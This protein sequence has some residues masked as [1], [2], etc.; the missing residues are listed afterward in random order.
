[1]PP[2]RRR[3]E[4]PLQRRLMRFWWR[5]LLVALVLYIGYTI[6]L[7][8]AYR[9][10]EAF[11]AGQ[12]E[13]VAAPPGPEDMALLP[14]GT[15]LL[16]GAIVSSQDRRDRAAPGALYFYDMSSRP[17]RFTRLELPASLVLHPHGL[18]L[19]TATDGQV[20]LHVINH[21]SS[22]RHTVEI[23]AVQLT[24]GAV[25]ALRHRGSV[26]SDLFIHPNG[27]AAAGP[28]SF[29]LTNDRGGG[30]GFIGPRWMHMMENLLQLS[31]STVVYHDG[32]GARVV[33]DNIA[34][35][36]GIEIT[37]DGSTVLVGSTQWRMLLAYTR[38]P[39]SGMLL[40]SGSLP[41]PGGADNVR[42]D[43]NGDLWVAAHPNAF[44]FIGHAMNAEKESPSIILR[45]SRDARGA[46]HTAEAFGDPGSLLSGASV[47]IQRQ[48][49]LLIGAVFQPTVLDCQLDTG[50]LRPI[51]N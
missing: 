10:T 41:L 4:K 3:D 28:E 25:P 6:W 17:G 13:A 36:N 26:A 24:V 43:A 23:F 33:A 22:D 1:M 14:E 7:S 9:S 34:F 46:V 21:R 37:G 45:L 5:F 42:R 29:Y 20:Y 16:P 8:G 18:S 49:R 27:I 32:R 12:C 19:F 39:N 48:G 15:G 31:R 47:G 2:R 35:A 51:E 44:A 38:E 50:K 30:I 11:V 40:R